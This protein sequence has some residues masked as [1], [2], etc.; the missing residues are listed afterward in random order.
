MVQKTILLSTELGVNAAVP[1]VVDQFSG[2]GSTG[3]I[4]FALVLRVA[5]Y[6]VEK[7]IDRQKQKKSKKSEI[8]E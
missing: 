1:A 2:S 3:Q 5:F 7:L 6:F 4:V 8:S